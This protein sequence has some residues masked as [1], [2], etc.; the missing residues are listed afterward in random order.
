MR[1]E[2]RVSSELSGEDLRNRFSEDGFCF[3]SSVIP[4]ELLDRVIKQMDAVIDGEFET[5]VP[6]QSYAY[7][8]D[9]PPEKLR[10]VN[11]PHLA[12]RT[13]LE[14]VSH[15]EIGRWA[16]AITGA[17]LVQ[18]WATQLLLKPPGGSDLGNVGW[19]QDMQHW[20]K[21]W[22]GEVFTAWVAISDVEPER[23]PM[24]FVRGSHHWGLNTNPSFFHDPDH[25]MQRE[26]I[27][28]PEGAAWEEV[29]A[30]LSAGC[31]S[32]HHRHTYHGSGPN[33][34]D[35]P[36]RSFAVHIRTEKAEPVDRVSQYYNQHLDDPAFC[37][38]IYES[39]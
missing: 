38:V 15:P 1:N 16:A 25:E 4:K 32:F 10:K 21:W 26:Q 6:P 29:P 34:S 36:R 9:D 12:D 2:K 3:T 20:T 27:P 35:K 17:E 11:Q 31:I 23:G 14:L 5:G 37:P 30:I 22:E 13:I 19:H 18:V 39:G 8:P 7:E 24:R 28:V 33:L